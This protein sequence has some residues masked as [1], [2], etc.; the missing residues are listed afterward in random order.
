MNKLTLISL[1]LITLFA[2]CGNQNKKKNLSE[3]NE[4]LYQ[5]KYSSGFD[6]K[7]VEDSPNHIIRIYNPWQGSSDYSTDFLVAKDGFTH[8]DITS[9][10]V[11]YA[12]SRIVCMS[13]THIAM[14]ESLGATE[15]IV[16]VSGLP[17]VSN[18]YIQQHKDSIPDIGYE[19]NINYETLVATNPD[20][21]LLFSVNGASSM[22]PKLRELGIPFIYIGDYVEENPLGKAEWIVVLGEL[23]GKQKEAVQIFQGI[24]ERY[25]D[26][27]QK[28][29]T[30]SLAY[31]P[32]V[33]VNAPFTGSWFMPSTKSYV[34]QMIEDAGGDYIYKKN[35]GNSSKPIDEEEALLLL[36]EADLWINIGTY[37]N[38]SELLNALPKYSDVP[39]VMNGNLF[40]N[41]A[42]TTPG[43]GNDCY[44]SGVMNPDIILRDM[45]K[46]FHPNLIKENF[47]YYHQLQ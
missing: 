30:D 7:W 43:G 2:A 35:T 6:I 18:S 11:S 22:E 17:Y 21:V 10:Y 5:P 31:K 15:K 45:I 20:I 39:C 4:F 9:N 28:I 3:Y 44:E 42:I 46:I 47:T 33:M 27:K 41:N 36:S 16:A 26:L 14:L 19:G 12:V 34:A 1:F 40:N 13:S 37:K 24:E 38:K 25:N 29:K 8:E 32:K 23:I